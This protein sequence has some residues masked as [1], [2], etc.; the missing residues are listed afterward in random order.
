MMNDLDLTDDPRRAAPSGCPAFACM[1][2]VTQTG[3]NI[4]YQKGNECEDGSKGSG[5]YGKSVK[6]TFKGEWDTDKEN[7][8]MANR[9]VQ[10]C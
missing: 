7:V 1:R 5:C 10:T 9:V 8:I 4:A 3:C 6:N 2:G